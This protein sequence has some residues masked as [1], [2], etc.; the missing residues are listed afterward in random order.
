MSAQ[1]QPNVSLMSAQCQP[2]VSPMSA[3]ADILFDLHSA[4]L[5]HGTLEDRRKW[6]GPSRGVRLVLRG[7]LWRKLCCVLF[8][9]DW[10]VS[11]AVSGRSKKASMYKA[12]P[13]GV[14]AGRRHSPSE[15]CSTNAQALG[16]TEDWQRVWAGQ[17]RHGTTLPSPGTGKGQWHCFRFC[18]T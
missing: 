5:R 8:S 11:V 15:I 14:A 6:P 9:L 10:F 1:C 7:M 4:S 3:R 12:R 2:N 16:W 17:T 13:Y 18:I